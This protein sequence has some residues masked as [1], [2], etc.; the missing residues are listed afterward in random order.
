ME[1]KAALLSR[2]DPCRFPERSAPSSMKSMRAPSSAPSSA[3]AFRTEFDE[4]SMSSR[5]HKRRVPL[6]IELTSEG[7]SPSIVATCWRSRFSFSVTLL[8]PLG[9]WKLRSPIVELAV[10]EPYGAA[11]VM[12]PAP[13]GKET[14]VKLLV[15]TKVGRRC[16]S[17]ARL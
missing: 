16:A 13:P 11:D 3:P 2:E 6:A 5:A 12:M 9:S 15:C 10:G 7:L 4:S 1:R 8:M 17:G 14:T